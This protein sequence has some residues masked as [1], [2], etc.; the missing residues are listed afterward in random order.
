M[1]TEETDPLPVG[2]FQNYSD[3][4]RPT[5][6]AQ[7]ESEGRSPSATSVV[8]FIHPKRSVTCVF[9]TATLASVVGSSFQFGYN[10]SVINTPERTIK[11][12]IGG[13]LSSNQTDLDSKVTTIFSIAV[14]I[15]AIG[16]LVGGLIA[17]LLAD[18]F[19]RKGSMLYNNIIAFIAAVL[20]GCSKPAS[21]YILLI[22]G[23]FV[24]GINCGINTILPTMYL[25]EISSV[26]QR[27]A[28]GVVHQ[29]FVV[30]GI[31]VSQVMGL[32]GIFGSSA[33]WP[34]AL[35][36]TAVPAFF[37]PLLFFAV[38]ESP[39]FLLI[40]KGNT[41]GAQT[42]LMRL[43]GAAYDSSELDQIKE[44]HEVEKRNPKIRWLS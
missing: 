8:P 13:I 30:V 44:E 16:G 41:D 14:S 21:S 42:A 3:D 10:T 1:T 39:R 15:W 37:Q 5:S 27:G 18:R 19:G 31:L 11:D 38:P 32:P 9:V 36:F 35:A 43:R 20:M 29:F 33:L 26:A 12:W 34:L 7:S 24:S 40:N 2:K 25:S 22:V 6:E 28:L 23:R 17:G 4:A